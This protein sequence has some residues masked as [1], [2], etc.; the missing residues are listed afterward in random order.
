MTKFLITCILLLQFA[1]S[2]AQQK[3]PVASGIVT[4]KDGKMAGF[5]QLQFIGEKVL[6]HNISTKKNEVYLLSEIAKISDDNQK[7]VYN[8]KFAEPESGAPKKDTLYKP[9]YPEGIYNTKE[10]FL[11]RKPSYKESLTPRSVTGREYYTNSIEDYCFFM[12]AGDSKLKKVFAVSYKGHLYFR[13]G[14]ILDHRNK[15]DRAQGSDFPQ[16]FVRVLIGGKNYYYTEAD[17]A[18]IW[19]QGF[20]YGAM[21]G[22]VG[23]ELGKSMINRK[24]VVWDIKNTEFNIFKNCKDYNKFIRPILP[25]AVQG[26]EDQQPELHEIRKA[27]LKIK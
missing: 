3:E 15:T 19:A 12:K 16:S 11:A 20:A 22:I 18:N 25:N 27:M 17:L 26:C 1:I 6:Y 7:I 8:G 9:D 4:H 21:G 5:V 14:A 2:A 24:G 23:H 13:T 10:D